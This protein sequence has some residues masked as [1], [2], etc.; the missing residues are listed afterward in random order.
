MRISCVVA[1][2]VGIRTVGRGAVGIALFAF[3]PAVGLTN[4]FVLGES[5]PA[6]TFDFIAW[7][8]V[9]TE[10]ARRAGA[11][12]AH[13]RHLCTITGHHVRAMARERPPP[14]R[15]AIHVPRPRNARRSE[16]ACSAAR[17]RDGRGRRPDGR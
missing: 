14:P 5:S 2:P 13:C 1:A 6:R 7:Y 4:T 10:M 11:S 3:F 8:S 16:R 15:I 9:V 17:V 12:P